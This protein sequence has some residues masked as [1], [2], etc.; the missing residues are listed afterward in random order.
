MKLTVAAAIAMA[1]AIA[2][3]TAS[4]GVVVTQTVTRKDQKG[5]EHKSE[6]T[7][8]VEGHKQKVI[9]G[10]QVYM[11]D[12]DAGKMTIMRT[13]NKLFAPGPFP[14]VGIFARVLARDGIAVGFKKAASA[15][16][17]LNG[18]LCQDYLGGQ[19]IAHANIG[20]IE[21]VS[22][23]APGAK[24]FTDFRRAMAAKLKGTPLAPNGDVPD[25]IPVATL[26]TV[27]MVAFAATGGISPDYLAKL[28]A[29]YNKHPGVT[30]LNVTKIEV[31]DIPPATFT[32]PA[33]YVKRE[34]PNPQPKMIQGR[35][36]Q[37]VPVPPPSMSKPQ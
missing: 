30:G 7:I 15:P 18:Y 14:P 26:T 29:D 4:A 27:T 6:Q 16:H 21:C 17:K 2:A 28:Q 34:M 3:T 24:E 22:S 32:V 19:T 1:L 31:K 13:S 25:G 35:G 12:L 23:D 8:M 20:V 33:D 5:V 9:N 36:G 37:P 10:E 11:I